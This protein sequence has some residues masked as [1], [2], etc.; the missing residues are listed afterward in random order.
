MI[1]NAP[2]AL[3]AP[4]EILESDTAELMEQGMISLAIGGKFG[5][6]H[7]GDSL[8]IFPSI[9]A[10]IGTGGVGESM[11]EFNL[12]Q[13]EEDGR[14]KGYDVERLLLAQKFVIWKPA[15]PQ[16]PS[17]AARFGVRLPADDASKGLGNDQTDFFA[18]GIFSG[19]LK[20]VEYRANFGIG[21]LGKINEVRGQDDVFEY[22]T[23]FI[24]KLGSK[25]HWMLEMSGNALTK[26]HPSQ[27]FATFGFGLCDDRKRQGVEL[28]ASFGLSDS[29]DDYRISAAWLTEVKWF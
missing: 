12:G 22:S 18:R 6:Q 13:V 27:R 20:N 15:D 9:K 14:I 19:R 3:A 21:I 25:G 7:D 29:S 8:Y 16:K 5:E 11:I 24:G 10:R 17:F 26:D 23:A 2:A 28:A 4:G 1:L